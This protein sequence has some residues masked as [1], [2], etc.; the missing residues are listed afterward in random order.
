MKTVEQ[1]AKEKD[2]TREAVYYLIKTNKIDFEKFGNRAYMIKETKRTKE[3][4]R[5]K[6]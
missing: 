4:K 1:F 6:K 2:I 3:Y 5:R